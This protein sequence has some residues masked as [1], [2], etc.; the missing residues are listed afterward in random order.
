MEKYSEIISYNDIIRF[1]VLT[2]IGKRQGPEITITS[3]I[4]GCE[5]SPIKTLY[6]LYK[7]INLDK[8]RGKINLIPIFDLQG[9]EKHTMFKCPIDKKNINR[10]F[11]G[12]KDGS[13]SEELV[14]N[15]FK[16][17]IKHVDYYIDLHSADLIEDMIPFIEVH[18]SGKKEIDKKSFL[19]A[20]HY[21]IKDITIKK[22][23][24]KVNDKGQSYSASSEAGVPAILANAGK[25][26]EKKG[27]D[28]H[29]ESLC[30]IL[31]YT[32]NFIGKAK[33]VKEITYYNPPVH[34]KSKAKGIFVSYVETGNYINK[35][36]I[37]GEVLEYDGDVKYS[38]KA[39]T[40]GKILLKN[41]S[42]A[43]KK[44]SLLLEI[45]NKR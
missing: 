45:L 25:I 16:D 15:I 37:V 31:K 36:E 1:P 26:R 33:Q 21:G 13:F 39:P 14:Y 41:V 44:G 3:G 27:E 5:Y 4:H 11:P 12:N 34:I 42:L 6:K 7:K 17:Y 9:F 29:F 18:E 2:I 43:V 20:E 40:D 19:L 35:D 38:V 23:K 32:G 10:V 22:I 30:N 28:I 8:V 24:G